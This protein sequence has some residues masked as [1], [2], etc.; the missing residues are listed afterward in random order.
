MSGGSGHIVIGLIRTQ[1]DVP[2]LEPMLNSPTKNSA[3][4]VEA[5]DLLEKKT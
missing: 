4:V 1:W 2:L 5:S 3:S